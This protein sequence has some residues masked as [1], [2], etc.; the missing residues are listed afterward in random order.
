V[1][2]SDCL[3]PP[4]YALLCSLFQVRKLDNML[5]ALESAGPSKARPFALSNG[6]E[7]RQR[8]ITTVKRTLRELIADPNSCAH[9]KLGK[10]KGLKSEGDAASDAT[11]CEPK[12]EKDAGPLTASEAAT[13]SLA[14]LVALKGSPGTSISKSKGTSGSWPAHEGWE[15]GTDSEG[16]AAGTP[17]MDDGVPSN[18]GAAGMGVS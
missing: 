16:M 12:E 7:E 14:S 10:V 4:V 11:P 9:L 15:E 13:D 5:V 17:P 8:K 18:R 2:V 3:S 1:P 6:E